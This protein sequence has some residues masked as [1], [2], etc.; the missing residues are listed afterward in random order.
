VGQNVRRKLLIGCGGL[1]ALVVVVLV[2]VL[3]LAVVNGDSNK[4]G[5]SGSSSSSSQPSSSSS[6]GKSGTDVSKQEFA[7][8]DIA[9]MTDRTF[10]VNDE[11]RNYTD[12]NGFTRPSSGNELVRTN[13]TITNT[14]NN[15]IS[16][17]PNDFKLQ[18]ANGVQRNYT[19]SRPCPP[20]STQE[21]L[22]PMVQ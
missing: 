7:V 18:D 2:V 20:L 1:V 3:V 5:S 16:F 4:T 9:N 15:Q 21:I 19:V 13:V 22:L 11:E 10:T 17:N 8:G 6:S 14:S 12:P